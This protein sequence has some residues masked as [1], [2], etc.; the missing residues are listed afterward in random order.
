MRKTM[1]KLFTLLLVICFLCNSLSTVKVLASSDNNASEVITIKEGGI[2]YN[3]IKSRENGKNTM[4][5]TSDANKDVYE[6][7][8]DTVKGIFHEDVHSYDGTDLGGS[9][10]YKTKSYDMNLYEEADEVQAQAWSSKIYDKWNGDHYYQRNTD[11]SY[12]IIGCDASYLI[13]YSGTAA[14]KVNDYKNAISACNNS[15]DSGVFYCGAAGVSVAVALNIIAINI[16]FPPTIIITI[17]SGIIGGSA[18]IHFLSEIV[19]NFVDSYNSFQDVRTT[20]K[21]ARDYGTM[22]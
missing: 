1:K 21:V 18:T 12:Y 10:K 6:I 3:I 11:S 2:T 22:Q 9:E 7:S 8:Y 20:Y 19:N 15:Y 14:E 13:K 17:L 5:V 16:V 4:T